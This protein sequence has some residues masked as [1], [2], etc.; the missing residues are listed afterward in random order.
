[1]VIRPIHT[2]ADHDAALRRIEVLWGAA[3]NTP[4]GNE[5]EIL[6]T[7]VES[8]ERTT[9]PMDV[10]GPLDAIKFRL[11]QLGEDYS[12]LI[13]V[14]GQRTR[15]YEVMRGAR[16][17]SLNMIRNLH[18]RMQIPAE[19]LLQDSRLRSRRLSRSRAASQARVRRLRKTA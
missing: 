7:L 10:P 12:A 16:P 1:M 6:A 2:A 3:P 19:V 17:L 8:Y 14:I 18:E 9:F 4:A 15:V 13:G 11:E 5:L